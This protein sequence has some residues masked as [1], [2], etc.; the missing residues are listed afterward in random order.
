[1]ARTE[2]ASAV[3]RYRE[4]VDAVVAQRTRLRGPQPPGDLFAGLPAGHPVLNVEPHRALS[5]NQERIAAF[6]QPDDIVVD[7]GGGA[8]RVSLPLALRCRDVINVDASGRDG[9]GV[10][11]QCPSCRS[12]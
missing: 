9:P 11:G 1:M 2:T 8:G 7:V 4:R 6:V 12:Q 3:G 10:P 5:P